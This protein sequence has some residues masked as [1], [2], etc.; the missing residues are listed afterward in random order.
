[1][2]LQKGEAMQFILVE[3]DQTIPML[4]KLRKTD[5]RERNY[6]MNEWI[7]YLL[8]DPGSYIAELQSMGYF[9]R[10]ELDL[11][12]LAKDKDYYQVDPGIYLIR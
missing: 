7:S 9:V 11:I 2:N 4:S 1:M 10:T 5:G 8:E 12:N 3:K 6:L